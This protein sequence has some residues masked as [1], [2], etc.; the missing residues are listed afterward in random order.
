MLVYE[1]EST[2]DLE[3]MLWRT[4]MIDYNSAIAVHDKDSMIRMLKTCDKLVEN[5]GYIYGNIHDLGRLCALKGFDIKGASRDIM[6]QMLIAGKNNSVYIPLIGIR[7]CNPF[8][9]NTPIIRPQYNRLLEYKYID[10]DILKEYISNSKHNYNDYL[11]LCGGRKDY[12]KWL[13]TIDKIIIDSNYKDANIHDIERLCYMRSIPLSDDVDKMREDLRS[14]DE[15][16][17]GS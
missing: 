16:I 1:D 14:L 4:L 15:N 2:Y 12:I 6:K 3:T 10:S 11:R 13:D 5:S 9:T 7:I 17:N 8:N